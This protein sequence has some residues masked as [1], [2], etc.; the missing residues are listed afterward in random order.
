[1]P[2]KQRPDAI[3]GRLCAGRRTAG[4]CGGGELQR[5]YN[6]R[7]LKRDLKVQSEG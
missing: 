2:D 7:E 1:M 6:H 5:S 3:A 4:H